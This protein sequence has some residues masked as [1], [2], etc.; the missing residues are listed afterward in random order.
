MPLP[1]LYRSDDGFRP[2]RITY[3]AACGA[4]LG[5]LAALFKTLAPLGV[6]GAGGGGGLSDRPAGIAEIAAVALVF[7]LLCT[8][9]A[10]LRNFLA[11]RLVWHDGR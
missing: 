2:W 3:A 9:A 10:M 7:A 4:A 1:S 8:G 6:G 5:A 11:R